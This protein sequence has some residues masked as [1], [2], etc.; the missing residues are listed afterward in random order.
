MTQGTTYQSI[1][2]ILADLKRI[3]VQAAECCTSAA[4]GSNSR[5]ALL[6]DMFRRHNEFLARSLSQSS[7]RDLDRALATWVQFV[8]TQQ[9]K[10]ALESLKEVPAEDVDEVVCRAM[11]LQNEII[12]ALH[13]LADSAKPTM[14]RHLLSEL[15]HL[16]QGQ[17]RELGWAYTTK[18][19]A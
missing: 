15:A 6:A 4:T 9:V 1:R 8:P 16:E 13:Q 3:H 10:E 11:T 18:K 14:A 5:P 7:D 2:E 17:M 12:T 19:D